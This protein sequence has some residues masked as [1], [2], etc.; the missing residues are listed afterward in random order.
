MG[1]LKGFMLRSERY[2]VGFHVNA[3]GAEV[4]VRVPDT[5]GKG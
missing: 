3:G 4:L 5:L 1:Q 2:F